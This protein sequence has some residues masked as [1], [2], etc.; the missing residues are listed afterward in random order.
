[1]D[2]T[3]NAQ[4]TYNGYRLPETIT[5]NG[6]KQYV[7]ALCIKEGST[8]TK[9]NYASGVTSLNDITEQKLYAD[10]IATTT[11]SDG[12]EALLFNSAEKLLFLTNHNAADI[13]IPETTDSIGKDYIIKDRNAGLNLRKNKSN[14]TYACRI[15][16][17]E[18]CRRKSLQT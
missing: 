7:V 8:Y 11:S 12:R 14:M 3:S 10:T 17:L 18:Y 15:C 2:K 1:M 13:A 9:T 5:V 16:P 6:K 4:E